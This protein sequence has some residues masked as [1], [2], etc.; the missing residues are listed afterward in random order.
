M[1]TRS[2]RR[3][4][5][6]QML[7]RRLQRWAQT[8]L[9]KTNCSQWQG[10]SDRYIV[11]DPGSVHAGL[12]IQTNRPGSKPAANSDKRR[13]SSTV[14]NMTETT[15]NAEKTASEKNSANNDKNSDNHTKKVE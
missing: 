14:Q 6:D 1:R 15:T 13:K 5:V 3:W 10:I 12:V 4:D 9:G 2:D 11:E 7:A 8:T